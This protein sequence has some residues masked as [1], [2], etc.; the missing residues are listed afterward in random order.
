VC[1]ICTFPVRSNLKICP[2]C[3][4]NTYTMHTALLPKREEDEFEDEF[5]GSGAQR[6]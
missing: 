6:Y 3:T 1:I 2:R 4:L 5:H